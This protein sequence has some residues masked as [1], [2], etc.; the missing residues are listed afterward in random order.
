MD[1]LLSG[2]SVAVQIELR[3]VEQIEEFGTELQI[4]PFAQ[5]E[6]EIFDDGEIRIH[7]TRTVDRRAGSGAKRADGEL[8]RSPATDRYSRKGSR[9]SGLKRARVEPVLVRMNLR[10]SSAGRVCG[11]RSGLVW[12]ANFVWP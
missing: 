11:N 5:S 10:G 12:I 4:H 3:V 7:E 9:R 6:W 8:L 1:I 2:V